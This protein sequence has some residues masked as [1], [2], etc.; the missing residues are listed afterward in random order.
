[1]AIFFKSKLPDRTVDSFHT[2]IARAAAM[3]A[4]ENPAEVL[5]L[6]R[7]ALA[8]A[9]AKDELDWKR[10]GLVLLFLAVLAAVGIVEY[11]LGKTAVSERFFS[12]AEKVFTVVLGLLAGE[13]TGRSS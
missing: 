7:E 10:L 8:N 13:A 9:P 2:A 4:T 1:M 3:Q 12:W 6:S 11:N 5:K